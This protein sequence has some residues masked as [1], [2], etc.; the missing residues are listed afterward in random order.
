MKGTR[1]KTSE[2]DE[3]HQSLLELAPFPVII[4]NLEDNLFV[5]A[6]KTHVLRCSRYQEYKVYFI[7]L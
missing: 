1:N 6:K 5:Y 3:Q 2:S 4:I 7:R